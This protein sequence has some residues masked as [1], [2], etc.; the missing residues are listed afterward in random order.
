[1]S[2]CNSQIWSVT[3]FSWY[4]QSVIHR[5]W[6]MSTFF[7]LSSIKITIFLTPWFTVNFAAFAPQPRWRRRP[8]LNLLYVCVGMLSFSIVLDW[9]KLVILQLLSIARDLQRKNSLDKVE[10]I[11]CS[12]HNPKK[13]T[14]RNNLFACRF[15]CSRGH[16]CKQMAFKKP[17]KCFHL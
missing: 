13:N 7:K 17:D 16:S 15:A 10:M 1:M 6:R 3:S 5:N 9:V 12:V 4:F 2:E 11:S 8:W 14:C